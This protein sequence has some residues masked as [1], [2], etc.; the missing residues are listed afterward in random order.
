M[1]WLGA[2]QVLLLVLLDASG[3]V[4]V[5]AGLSIQSSLVHLDN[6]QTKAANTSGCEG[7]VLLSRNGTEMMVCD[8]DWSSRSPLAHVVC[9]EAGCGPPVGIWRNHSLLPLSLAAMQGFQCQGTESNTSECQQ[10]GDIVEDCSEEHIAT[11]MCSRNSTT[12]LDLNL[13]ESVR[14]VGGRSKCDGHVELL[15]EARWGLLCSSALQPKKAHVLCKQI[16]CKAQQISFTSTSHNPQSERMLPIWSDYIICHGNESSLSECQWKASNSCASAQHVYLHCLQ[17]RL[18]ESWIVWMAIIFAALMIVVFCWVRV[19]KSWKNCMQVVQKQSSRF[20]N[21]FTKVWNSCRGTPA[22]RRRTYQREPP[23]VRVQ[24]TQ[25]PPGTPSI[26]QN[27]EEVNALLAP[28][29]FRLNNTITPPPSYMNA[30]KVL[31]RPLEKTQTPP[32][33]YLEALRILSRPVIVHVPAPTYTEEEELIASQ[34]NE[35]QDL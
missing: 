30:L 16:G 5:V 19:I 25:S 8:N 4:D 34:T 18:E 10:L 13:N 27:V 14:L 12:Q 32:P 17:G 6:N 22:R 2:A 7:L 28:H 3:V 23:E 15:Q 11:L 9:H 29:G 35:K 21:Y 20:F 33:S 26:I 1:C 31:S 24:E